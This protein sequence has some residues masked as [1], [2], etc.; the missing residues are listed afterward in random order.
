[1]R[2]ITR[3][4]FALALYSAFAIPH[5]AFAQSRTVL[6]NPAVQTDINMSAHKLTNL[7]ATVLADWGIT[8]ALNRTDADALYVPLART[9][10]GHALN[11]NVT[12]TAA[13]VGAPSGSG[14]STGT[15]TGD[16]VVP[17]TTTATASNWL[18]SYDA[19][20]GAF[21]KSQPNFTDLAGTAAIA[22]IPTG[23]TASTVALGDKGVTTLSLTTPGVLYT[24][25]VTFTNTGGAWSGTLSLIN[26]AANTVF[27]NFAGSS[28]TPT[29]SATPAFNGANITALSAANIT[30]STTI[31]RN[32]LNLTNPSAITFPRYNADNTVTARTAAQLKTDLSLTPGT[33]IQAFDPDLSALA[34][35]SGTNTIYYRS[36]A[37]TWSAVTIGSN[38]TFSAG[39]LSAAPA[40]AESDPVFLNSYAASGDLVTFDGSATATLPVGANHTFLM[41]DNTVP[42]GLSWPT[43]A[44]ARSFL[45]LGTASTAN[46]GTSGANVP[47]LNVANTWGATQTFTSPVINS[48]ATG[49]GVASGATASTLASRDANANLTANNWLG[50]YTTTATAAGT[51]TLTVGSAYGEW[52]TGSST[53]TITLPVASTLTLG[54]Q[55]II[56]NKS[57]GNVTVNSSG[58]NTVVVLAGGTSATVT[59][60][61]TSGTT[62]ASWDASYGAVAV[63]SGKKLTVS[64]SY[65]TTATDGSTVAFGAGGTVLYSGGALGTPASGTLTNAT[66]LP[67]TTGVT[68]T[69][70]V[71]NGGTGDTGTAWTAYTP[72]IT[73]QTGSITTL[74]Y[75]VGSYKQIGKTVI[76]RIDFAITTNGTGAT[77]LRASLPFTAAANQYAMSGH[78]YTN[79]KSISGLIGASGTY[80]TVF[81]Y[82]GTYPGANGRAYNMVGIYEVP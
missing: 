47:I 81:Y 25:P 54:H 17:A 16:Q 79:G 62:A 80:T 46:T 24:S 68:G 4:V 72:A 55:F 67:L 64:N 44:N 50:G 63:A 20:T 26:Q 66:G 78:E 18:R 36:A 31:G 48:L 28:A 71:A 15:N 8:N 43:A 40:P 76:V 2:T 74:G 56:Q 41:A 69:L 82:D 42:E 51:T 27:G 13:D 53:Q 59:C 60:I 38:L 77:Q 37:N 6:N 57:S 9:V 75:N 65:T 32:L 33:D 1:M 11:A 70:P 12:V 19:T 45:G 52:F 39:T 10:N 7:P 22:Q 14:T 5:S 58:G 3:F 49:T 34:A 73:C 35:L 21:T 29:F 61:L 23:A 30:A